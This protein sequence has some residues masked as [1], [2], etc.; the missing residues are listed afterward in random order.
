M[1][2]KTIKRRIEAVRGLL[3]RN[4]IRCL[5]LTRRANVSYATGFSG[6]DSWAVITNRAVYLL[7]DSRY[8][9]QAEKE[10]PSCKII[11]RERAIAEAAAKLTEKL[12]SLDAVHVEKAASLATF[13][14]LRKNV[15]HRI[16]TVA[17]IIEPVR[18]IKTGPEISAIRGAARTAVNALKQAVCQVKP[19][20]TENEL[21]GRL[22]LEIR[23]LGARNSFETIVAFGPNASRPHHQPGV[24]KLKKNDTILID[25]G[26][27]HKNYCCD[28]TRC[29]AVGRA[30]A[31]FKRAYR[32]VKEAQ[33][34]A[35]RMVRAGVDAR[36]V[37][38]A[39]REVIAGYDLPVYGH[40]TGH[41]LGLEVHEEPV[42]SAER[43]GKLE[44]GMVLTIEPG[45][46]IPGKIGVR[47]E[48]DVLV[49]KNGHTV[50]SSGP[51]HSCLPP[52]WQT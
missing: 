24:R 12:R 47:I 41:G 29:Y 8:T 20:I 38:A 28:L 46:Y 37:D 2:S 21:A 45:V 50:L 39:A 44:A 3:K 4:G 43:K 52:L 31:L 18:L 23:R 27:K 22:D 33:A 51:P 35:I 13:E 19:G 9:E 1:D 48:D 26:V 25:F 10:C 16:K 40:G 36:R 49:T 17:N 6:D 11:Q 42:I 30:G 34:A 7:T 5:I 15:K 32:A 14:A